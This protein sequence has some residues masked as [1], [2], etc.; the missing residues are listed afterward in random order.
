MNKSN[1]TKSKTIRNKSK[2]TRPNRLINP[3]EFV[4]MDKEMEEE[5]ALSKKYGA[6]FYGED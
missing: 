2:N 6:K 1:K 3:Q 5:K 4:E